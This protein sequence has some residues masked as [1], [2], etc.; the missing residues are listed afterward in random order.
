MSAEFESGEGE[1]Y[2][3]L[4]DSDLDQVFEKSHLLPRGTFCA[5]ELEAHLGL[6]RA[7]RVGAVVQSTCVGVTPLSASGY[8]G[9][10]F[11]FA[12][13]ARARSCC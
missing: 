8:N 1:N 7:D 9:L 5:E 3:Y 12:G 6:Q 2:A 11:V 10:D 4:Q 13:W